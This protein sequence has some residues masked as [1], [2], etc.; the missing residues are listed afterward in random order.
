MKVRPPTD[1]SVQL[2]LIDFQIDGLS[3][4]IHMPARDADHARRFAMFLGGEVIGTDLQQANAHIKP[5][6]LMAF[7]E[8]ILGG[9]SLPWPPNAEEQIGGYLDQPREIPILKLD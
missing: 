3:Y 2:Y 4:G 5:E 6:Q 7:V 9:K 1:P 8:F